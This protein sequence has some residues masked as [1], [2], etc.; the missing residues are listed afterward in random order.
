[1]AIKWND[2]KV[3]HV[4][5]VVGPTKTRCD[6]VMSDI[7]ANQTYVKVFDPTSKTVDWVLVSSSFEL[8]TRHGLVD[9]DIE[10]GQ[11]AQD[12]QDYLDECARQAEEAKKAQEA[13][14]LA[15]KEED[16]KR[17]LLEPAKGV[18]CKVVKGRKV[19]KGTTG[20][21]FWVG[22]K[23]Y[24][25]TVGFLDSTGAKHFTSA[26]NV[27]TT[28]FG[29]DFGQDP[30][31]MTWLELKQ[32]VEDA[33]D[34]A[35]SASTRPISGHLVRLK[36]DATQIGT[37]F[38]VKENRIGFKKTRKS[39]PIWA[40]ADEVFFVDP[41]GNEWEYKTVVATL[42]N[43]SKPTPAPA[44][45]PTTPEPPKTNPLAEFPAPLCDIRQITK[46]DKGKWVA[47]DGEGLLITLLPEQTALELGALLV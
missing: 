14:I 42:P 43:F 26:S 16:A 10:S 8:E 38:W 31:G 29:L 17:F 21:I 47:L 37:V 32:K 39:D 1:M 13:R 25:L 4:G 7:Y 2:G 22:D 41:N 18:R 20:E 19:P 5:C 15:Q 35:Y 40:N 24:G 23:G 44:Q 12:Y 9:Y 6:R 30:V 34:K 33:H 28:A 46:N 36:S 11:Y 3:T 27:I 45:A